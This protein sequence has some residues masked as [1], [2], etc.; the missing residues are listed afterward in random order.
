MQC[1]GLGSF[2]P[3]SFVPLAESEGVGARVGGSGKDGQGME[4]LS[5]MVEERIIW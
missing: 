4:Q 3:I 2:L 1:E 5:R